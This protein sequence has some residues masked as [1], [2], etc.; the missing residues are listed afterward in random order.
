MNIEKINT[1]IFPL[2]K[3]FQSVKAAET[4]IMLTEEMII[5]E[6]SFRCGTIFNVIGWKEIN[7]KPYLILSKGSWEAI[8]D[9][10][11]INDKILRIYAK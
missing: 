1:S 5:H 3:R 2:V 8:V 4:G 11:K 9:I 6:K 7:E 10:S